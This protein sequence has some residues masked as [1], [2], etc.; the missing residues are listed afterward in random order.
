MQ[1]ELE[2][3]LRLGPR[4]RK[5][6]RNQREVLQNAVASGTPDEIVSAARTLVGIERE[7]DAVVERKRPEARARVIRFRITDA[8]YADLAETALEYRLDANEVAR[9]LFDSGRRFTD[10]FWAHVKHGGTSETLFSRGP[11]GHNPLPG[12]ILPDFTRREP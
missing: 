1:P 5:R 3:A 9:R 12:F 11:T 10:C 8:E 6:L 4:I 7:A 2:R